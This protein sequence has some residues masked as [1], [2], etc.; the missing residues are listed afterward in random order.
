M[1]WSM[2]F[3]HNT[4]VPPADLCLNKATSG[5][6]LSSEFSSEQYSSLKS[7]MQW[8]SSEE[9]IWGSLKNIKSGLVRLVIFFR[10]YRFRF[11]PSTFQVSE[12]RVEADFE[13]F[14]MA[15]WGAGKLAGAGEAIG[16]VAGIPREALDKDCCDDE[17]RSWLCG[18]ANFASTELVELSVLISFLEH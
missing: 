9:N 7:D 4:I 13:E 16:G 3:F 6:C 12:V 11:N 14:L 17:E 2:D 10:L 15:V 1:Y 5:F 8:G 18:V